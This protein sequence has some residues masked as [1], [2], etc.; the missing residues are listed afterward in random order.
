MPEVFQR[1]LMS[2]PEALSLNAQAALGPVVAPERS[3]FSHLVRHFLER[4]FNHEDSAASGDGK[5]RLVQI[6]CATGLPGTI[7]AMYLWPVYHRFQGWPPH[8]KQ[9]GA[10]PYWVQMNH[11]FFFVM[12]SFVVMGLI[13]VFEWDHFF[14]DLLDVFVLGALPIAPL[15]QF[16]ARIGAIAI[17][18]AGFLLDANVLAIPMLPIATDPPQLMPMVTGHAVSVA[19]SGLFAAGLVLALQGTLLAVLGEKL[20]RRVSLLL[21]GGMVAGFLLLLLLFPVLSGVTPALLQADGAAARWFPP[22]WFLA[23]FQQHLPGAT[24]LATWAQLA[25]RGMMMTAAIWLAAV[26]TYPLAHL[27]RTRALVQGTWTRGRRNWMLTPLNGVLHATILR[28]PVR[29]AVFHFISQTILRVPRYRIYLVLYCGVG[30]SLV[31][32]SILRLEVHGGHLH[33]A[34]SADGMRVAI[35]IIAFWIV[36]GLRST[37]ASPGNQQGGWILRAIHGK[38]PEYGAARQQLQAATL[39]AFIVAAAVTLAAIGAFQWVT[40][41]ELRTWPSLVAEVLTGL[42]LCLVLTDAFFLNVMSIP[43]TGQ[44]AGQSPE[45]G[46]SLALTV[47]RFYTF[48]PAVI[49]LAV[50]MEHLMERGGAR[51]GAAVVVMATAHLWLRKRHRDVVRIECA[52]IAAEEGEENFPL[53]LGLRY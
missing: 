46:D 3:Q 14:P 43:F 15:R 30:F 19:L 17:F 2:G 4:F 45:P 23:M 6:A 49:A 35:G 1:L 41:E 13:T 34:Y 53:R 29:R 33:A 7:V 25:H 52:Q 9:V 26:A 50:F 47:L 18:I 31:V 22:F 37:F 20:F 11:H 32:A 21:Q 51:L 28:A 10:P 27:R 40:P 5:T 8:S 39:W 24:H 48:F 12:Y 16:R 44:R 36:A 38:P 42:G